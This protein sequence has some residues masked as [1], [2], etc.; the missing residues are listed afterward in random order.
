[1][2]VFTALSV[3]AAAAAALLC[4]S[5]VYTLDKLK[6]KLSRI[7][8]GYT[9]RNVCPAAQLADLVLF[10][11][12]FL[13][14]LRC[15]SPFLAIEVLGQLACSLVAA[16]PFCD[17]EFHW[18]RLTNPLSCLQQPLRAW[19]SQ[20]AGRPAGKPNRKTSCTSTY[21]MNQFG[22]KTTLYILLTPPCSSS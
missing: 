16:L 13:S 7:R 21:R 2:R 15:F 22:D 1:M 3:A 11:L 6:F 18:N 5:L 19:V 10:L 9:S 14:R 8:P 12:F 17:G 20:P 4:C